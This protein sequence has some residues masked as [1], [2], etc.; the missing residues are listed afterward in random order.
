VVTY[1]QCGYIWINGQG[2]YETNMGF[3]YQ[4]S[5]GMFAAG[6]APSGAA[7][8]HFSVRGMTHTPRLAA[9]AIWRASEITGAEYR[10]VTE[11]ARHVFMAKDGRMLA[12]WQ[13]RYTAD[14]SSTWRR[15]WAQSTNEN[16][17][18]FGGASV[19]QTTASI[20]SW[21]GER[22]Q[23]YHDEATDNIY[24]VFLVWGSG[25]HQTHFVKFTKITGGGWSAGSMVQLAS[26]VSGVSD[27]IGIVRVPGTGRLWFMIPYGNYNYMGLY[28]SDNDGASWTQISSL[29]NIRYTSNTPTELVAWNSKVLMVYR[30]Y[31]GTIIYARERDDTQANKQTWGAAV[32]LYTGQ[33]A[34]DAGWT[35]RYQLILTNH[36][37][38]T[39]L[40]CLRLSNG[41]IVVKK[42]LDGTGWVAGDTTVAAGVASG[43][44]R[45][46]WDGA[47]GRL[48]VW[49]STNNAA[50]EYDPANNSYTR[51]WWDPCPVY[52][53]NVR[54][55]RCFPFL[56]K[57]GISNSGLVG[58]IAFVWQYPK[59][60]TR[61]APLETLVS[62]Y[63][64]FDVPVDVSGYPLTLYTFDLPLESGGGV[65][66]HIQILLDAST[67]L[68]WGR[69][70]RFEIINGLYRRAD[71]PLDAMGIW[72]AI[73]HRWL[74]Q[75]YGVGDLRH[76]WRVLQKASVG[77]LAHSWSVLTVQ[78]DEL[79]HL[80]RVLQ[81]E[82]IRLHGEDVQFPHGI[83]EKVT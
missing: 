66:H 59:E 61:T 65:G 48:V 11:G 3:A 80:W 58:V 68:Q 23:A 9:R 28:Y 20:G 45:A 44:C 51:V 14:A 46:M 33:T 72:H 12:Y 70:V 42:Y 7:V 52:L 13:S 19:L 27:N 8:T 76:L 2:P 32:S 31:D 78:G 24:V 62:R 79:S 69:D 26:G 5:A 37:N 55:G 71:V 25:G 16:P 38:A 77:N 49:A 39:C 35:H 15:Y 50:I 34:S 29:D 1:R 56:L 60:F 40:L 75:N 73:Y 81:P 82:L 18:S 54:Y 4:A 10:G 22:C 53:N 47:R 6:T 67:T 36:A 30:S 64:T 21:Y 83:I 63:R 41:N 74:V 43:V 57:R 17:S